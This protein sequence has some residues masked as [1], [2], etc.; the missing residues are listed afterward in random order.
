MSWLGSLQGA[1]RRNRMNMLG[2]LQGE[3]ELV[4]NCLSC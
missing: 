1:G 2:M 4:A 3:K